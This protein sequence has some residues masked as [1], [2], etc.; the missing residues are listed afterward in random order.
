M[1]FA[2]FNLQLVSCK[3]LFDGH[4]KVVYLRLRVVLPILAICFEFGYSLRKIV[5]DMLIW[6]LGNFGYFIKIGKSMF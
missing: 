5:T 2:C 4:K 1:L 3:T 6:I